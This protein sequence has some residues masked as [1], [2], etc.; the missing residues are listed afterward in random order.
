M[1][2]PDSPGE[3][4]AVDKGDISADE[5]F[6]S[7]E[8]HLPTTLSDVLRVIREIATAEDPSGLVQV[9]LVPALVRLRVADREEAIRAANQALKVGI[10]MLRDAVAEVKR[11]ET[12]AWRASAELEP[13]SSASQTDRLVHLAQRQYKLGISTDGEPFAVPKDGPF[14]AKELRTSSDGLRAELVVAYLECHGKVPSS[15]L[16]AD[17]MLAVEG[18]ARQEVPTELHLRSVV[19]R[20]A[21]WVDLG[22]PLGLTVKVTPQ[23]W[24]IE[25]RAP[26]LFRRTP[27][28]GELPLPTTAAADAPDAALPSAMVG[29]ERL[30]R[31]IGLDPHPEMW[32]L[33]LGWLVTALR[34]NIPRPVLA[35]VG[36]QGSAK[37]T[38]ARMLVGLV[39]PSPAAVRSA[40][41]NDRDWHTV[42]AGSAVVALDNLSGVPDWLSDLICRAVTGE[43]YPRRRLYTDGD[44][45]VDAY[46]R[47]ILLTGI[48]LGA[49]RGDLLD[50]ALVLELPRIAENQR[51]P[52]ADVMAEYEAAR[53]EIFCGLLSLIAATLRHESNVRL[54]SLP[55]MADHARLLAALD[56]AADTDT[57]NAYLRNST[58]SLARA[59]DADHVA[60]A[61]SA[62]ITDEGEWRGI[63]TDLLATLDH[64]RGEDRPP[65]KWPT[66]AHHFAG[67]L[68][69]AAPSLRAAGFKVEDDGYDSG[70][71]RVWSLA[72]PGR[73]EI[74]AGK[75]QQRQ[76][77]GEADAPDA[78][79]ADSP[80]TLYD[81]EE[82][83][84]FD[85]FREDL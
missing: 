34:S 25:S 56:E 62:L 41:R 30:R 24:S 78:A 77:T 15:S 51:R 81:R 4:P 28:T 54:K 58:D 11:A 18:L 61:V 35:L 74:S 59:V 76:S 71:R 19:N 20:D 44:I 2:V 66:T 69:K 23:R 83:F 64:R 16:L 48:D 42:A 37:T 46:Q 8:T 5:I 67:R 50:R 29:V 26:V 31:L 6:G 7:D 72:H 68:R 36:E 17:A 9:E 22:G 38:T 33:V 39:D 55:R 14:I 82:G 65:R 53:A 49:L 1:P 52:Q 21:L 73:L 79:S 57:L 63:A 60:L 80:A 10:G 70:G 3:E 13:D 27:L 47:S 43:A 75:R 45:V 40:P 32:N 85:E 12:A 84:Q